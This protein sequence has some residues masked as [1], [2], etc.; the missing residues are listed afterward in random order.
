MQR[1]TYILISFLQV[2]ICF[3]QDN[4]ATDDYISFYQKF[5]SNQKNSRCAMYPSCSRYGQMAFKQ[6]SFTKAITLTCE[7]IMRCSHDAPFYDIT[8]QY[9]NRSLIDYPQENVLTQI[10]HNR[11]QSPHT[12]VLKQRDDRDDNLLFINYLIN[13]EEYHP[14]LLEIERLLFFN[15][16][17]I[18][19][20]K[21]KLLCRRGLKEYEE[22]IFEYETEFPD[23]IRRNSEIQM[24]AALL[25]YCADNFN[26]AIKLV[27]TVK[28]NAVNLSDIQKANTLLGILSAQ[29][30]EYDASLASFHRNVALPSFD[31]QNIDIIS[32]MMQQKKKKPALARFLSIIP[33]GGFL[34]TQHKGSALTAFIINSVL[35]YATYTSIKSKNYGMAG[36]CGFLSLSFYIGNINGAGRSATRYNSKKKNE[37]IRKLERIN[38]I[39][40][41]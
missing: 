20:Y 38:N 4:A 7:R 12:D 30:E 24:Q 17:N 16:G 35:G 14:A 40:I 10:I 22:G 31:Q 23:T 26:N 33:G 34:Y 11:F 25:Y 19:L 36:V 32:Q 21:Q 2:S 9:G 37:Q 41:N 8:Y 27:E 1:Y 28:A 6:F 29:N 3:A 13:K 18:Q 39:F 5:L 15:Q